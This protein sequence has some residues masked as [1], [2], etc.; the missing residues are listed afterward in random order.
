MKNW[1]SLSSLKGLIL[2]LHFPFFSLIV[3]PSINSHWHCLSH[4]ASLFF[5]FICSETS[6]NTSS[7]LPP[8]LSI[9]VQFGCQ[10]PTSKGVDEHKGSCRGNSIWSTE[11]KSHLFKSEIG[12]KSIAINLGSPC[13]CTEVLFGINPET[14][15][16]FL[17]FK[18]NSQIP[19]LMIGQKQFLF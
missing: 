6:E 9:C 14:C 10:K 15:A 3:S 12:I 18:K 11:Q 1:F 4:E 7:Y 2:T 13:R 17:T 8:T 16:S 19:A 5:P